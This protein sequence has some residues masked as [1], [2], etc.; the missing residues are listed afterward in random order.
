MV[1][2]RKVIQLLI[3]L[4]LVVAALPSIMGWGGD[5]KDVR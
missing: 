4:A 5:R 1:P 2:A 3:A